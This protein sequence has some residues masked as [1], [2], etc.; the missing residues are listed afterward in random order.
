MRHTVVFAVHSVVRVLIFE[1]DTPGGFNCSIDCSTLSSSATGAA[2]VDYHD[3]N[4]VLVPR[5]ASCY[6][7]TCKYWTCETRDLCQNR[8]RSFLCLNTFCLYVA[9]EFLL[10]FRQH[11]HPEGVTLAG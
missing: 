1:P 7:I 5:V 4:L 6:S 3:H 10:L 8:V 2:I 9:E 11:L